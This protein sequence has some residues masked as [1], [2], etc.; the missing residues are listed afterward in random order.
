MVGQVMYFT[1][2]RRVRRDD[3]A[4]AKRR[5]SV[6]DWERWRAAGSRRERKWTWLAFDYDSPAELFMPD[7]KGRA[8]T[9]GVLRYGSGSNPLRSRGTAV[10]QAQRSWMQIGDGLNNDE[11]G[12]FYEIANIP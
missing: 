10:G 6:S 7:R 1:S 3:V 4:I 11:T 12:Q 5:L 8:A 9:D 2:H